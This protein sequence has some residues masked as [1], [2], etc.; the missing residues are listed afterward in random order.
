MSK[1]YKDI[2]GLKSGRLKAVS[3][4][5][6]SKNNGNMWH[7]I[8][9]CG[10]KTIVGESALKGGHTLSCGCLRRD[11]SRANA[12]HGMTGTTIY[13]RWTSM[14]QRCTN[15]KSV[16]FE[17]YGGRGI[18]YDPHWENFEN[19]FEDM[20]EGFRDDLELDRIDVNGNYCKENCRWATHSE[21]NFNKTIQ[22]NNVSG[23][24]GVSFRQDTGKYRAYIT[25]KGRQIS[26]GVFSNIEEAIE[27]R[28][29]A[30]IE[31]YGYNRD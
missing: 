2:T 28:K 1:M 30:E 14:K 13:R 4:S 3:H 24:T 7:C 6:K 19:F 31:Y 5:H 23:K 16:N 11:S 15:P 8:C 21:N 18:T 12:K 22:V 20:A 9:E 25:F 17:I 27:R 29:M 26:L 10:N